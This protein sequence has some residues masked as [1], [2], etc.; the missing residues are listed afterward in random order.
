MIELTNLSRHYSMAHS[1]VAVLSQLNLSVEATERVAIVGPSG[2]GKTTL[3]LILTG[4]ESP[5]DGTVQI[6]QQALTEMTADQR[7]DLRRQHIGIVFQ[8]LSLI[9]I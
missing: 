7:A 3:L 1:E 5:S 4:L 8:S 9:H 2:S 6:A